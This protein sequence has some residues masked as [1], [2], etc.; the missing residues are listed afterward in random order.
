LAHGRG[1]LSSLAAAQSKTAFKEFLT[2]VEGST[3]LSTLSLK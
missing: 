3:T 2:Q 1:T